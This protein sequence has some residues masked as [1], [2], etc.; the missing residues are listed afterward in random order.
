MTGTAQTK[1]GRALELADDGGRRAYV[2]RLDGEVVA[3][4]YYRRS[5]GL[6]TFTH[7]ETD[8][9]LE[10]QG[11]ASALVRFALDDVRARGD[12]R[13]RPQCPFVRSWLERHPGT[14]DDL[15][16]PAGA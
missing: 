16:Q 11:V 14:Y 7:T 3:S 9:A 13:V 10:G 8:D 2:A 5:A 15:L 12:E 4:A 1:D 6:I